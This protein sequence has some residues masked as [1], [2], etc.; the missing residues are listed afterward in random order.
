MRPNEDSD[1][2]NWSPAM[3][4]ATLLPKDAVKFLFEEARALFEAGHLFLL[5]ALH[6]GC[7]DPGHGPL[8]RMFNDVSNAS[9]IL[10]SQGNNSQAIRLEL[11]P[12]PYFPDVPLSELAKMVEGEGG[13]LLE[14]R[15]ALRFWARTIAN[16]DKFETREVVR[17]CYEQVEYGLREVERKF[18]DLA[19]RLDWAHKGGNIH[20]YALDAEKLEIQPQDLAAA[21]LVALHSELR[22]SPWYAYFRLSSQGYRWNLM[23]KGA[24]STVKSLKEFRPDRVHHWLVPP[25][26]G[27]A[28]PAVMT[29]MAMSEE[30]SLPSEKD[31]TG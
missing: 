11:L 18:K 30:A 2:W 20:S 31:V 22:A 25:Q 28:I 12:L 6:V 10:S 1:D 3:G 8:E 15:Q 5:P 23:R 4:W 14:T 19:R 13:S 17:E 7:I 21:E 26:A 9:P 16:R 29:R 24:K 27:W